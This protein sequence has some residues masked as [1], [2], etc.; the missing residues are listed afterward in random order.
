MSTE[1]QILEALQK[2]V[3][4]AVAASANPSLPV[5]YVGRT[6]KTP[7]SGMWLEVLYIPNNILNEFWDESKTYQGILR[8][9]FHSI[10]DDS[11]A[12]AATDLAES[13]ASYFA[14][15]LTL[16]DPSESVNVRIVENANLLSI[17]EQAPEMLLPVSIRYQFFK[18]A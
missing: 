14:K 3:T 1:R 2:A 9:L 8:L 10:M 16:T 6:F 4:A 15:G 11:G 18:P 5:K 17:I 13:V 12:Y 7:N